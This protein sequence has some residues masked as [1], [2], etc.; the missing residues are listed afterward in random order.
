MKSE[1][2]KRRQSIRFLWE[3]IGKQKTNILL[4][5]L[6]QIALGAAAVLQAGV[7]RN[8][9][10]HAVAKSEDGFL[11]AAVFF[12]I[13]IVV[14]LALRAIIRPL[15]EYTKATIE[16]SFKTRLFRTILYV[17]YSY[18][19]D[20]HSGEWMN[21]LTSDTSVVANNITEIIP[22][23]IGMLTRMGGAIIYMVILFPEL[24]LFLIPAAILIGGAA[25]FFRN[26][27]KQL[28]TRIQ[29]EDGRLRV[30][31][32]ERI[33]NMLIV[34]SFQKERH[35]LI[36]ASE[37]MKAHR[38]ARLK[39]SN[40]S[41][42]LQLSYGVFFQGTY[43]VA[44]LICCYR[45][46]KGFMTYGTFTAVLHLIAQIQSPMANISGFVPRYYAM[47]SSA[48]RLMEAE[49][50]LP[51]PE[52]EESLRTD[53]NAYYRDCFK[54]IY[55]DHVDYTY[56]NEDRKLQVLSDFSMQIAAGDYVAITGPSGCG[57]STLLKLL[58]GL[59]M[60]DQGQILVEEK[61]NTVPLT[62]IHRNLFAY[63]PQGNQLMA[64]TIREVVSF[65]DSDGMKQEERLWQALCIACAETFVKDLPEGLDTT[66]GEK[67]TGLSEGQMQR[68]A[69][70]R[71]VFSE[72]PILL[73]DEATSSLDENT[74]QRLLCNLKSMTDRTVLIITHR[75]GALAICN[76][77]ISMKNLKTSGVVSYDKT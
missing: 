77:R 52:K 75:P 1:F 27:L 11:R 22:D 50:Y 16:N 3:T 33:Q 23:A 63:V 60:P 32:T 56:Q 53:V 20:V 59:Y 2:I 71:A 35:S 72:H 8:V 43:L 5:T 31:L 74:E 47:I 7:M 6:I 10:D 66:L 29:Q 39:R 64:G 14:Q 37:R 40:T 26:R 58:M 62:R 69:I 38:N 12:A 25:L 73:L 70:A 44:A 13:V 49:S 41:N 68:I 21:R 76:Q 42:L 24:T 19:T 18:V 45:I 65:G 48:E 46:L 55:I 34:R 28:H 36:G 67:G 9:V 54:G 51:E 17:E 57:K 61:T 4:M 15:R 30:Y